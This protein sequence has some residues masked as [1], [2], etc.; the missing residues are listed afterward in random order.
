MTTSQDDPR[1]GRL[2]QLPPAAQWGLLLALSAILAALL[3]RAGVPAAL[4]LGPMIAGILLGVNGAGVRIPSLPYVGAQ[5]IIGCL[6][7][8]AMSGEIVGAFA[9]EWPLFLAIVLTTIAASSVLGWAMTRWSALPGT[10]AVW[11]AS[12]G[13]ATAMMVMAEAFGADAQLVA[14]MQYLRVVFVA[15]A[16]SVIARLWLHATAGAPPE[17]VWF[18]AIDWPPLLRTLALAT[19]GALIGAV[20]RVPAGALLIP[21]AAGAALHMT[22]LMQI[23]LPPW[24][25]AISYALLGWRIG[26]GF[27][28][29]ILIHAS[30]ALPQII[31]SIVAL[32]VFCCGLALLLVRLLGVDPLTAY[33]A[34]SPGGMD[35]IAII[36]ASSKVDVA[37][38][39]ALQ[40]A[41]LVIVILVGPRLARLIAG[42]MTKADDFVEGRDA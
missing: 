9:R 13:A 10:T 34:T 26:L 27:T 22:G 5:A 16:A 8:R 32:I 37:F 24:L 29:R 14:F 39:M 11:G 36:A 31:L 15:V 28:R 42:R 21:A 2:A 4:L 3:A 12:P 30:R 20:L 19:G 33:L 38:V 35:S 6:I 1:R 23:D 25:L 18:A 7:A 40:T 17:I 41:R